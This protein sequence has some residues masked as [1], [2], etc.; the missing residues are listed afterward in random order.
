[1][2]HPSGHGLVHDYGDEGHGVAQYM[3]KHSEVTGW[4]KGLI[5]GPHRGGEP[6]VRG[7]HYSLKSKADV[8]RLTRAAKRR[9][10]RVEYANGGP[11]G[12]HV[13]IKYK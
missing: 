12:H 5:K 3:A 10:H 2:K 9:G 7:V 6:S 1:M 11:S 13:T 8:G 4:A